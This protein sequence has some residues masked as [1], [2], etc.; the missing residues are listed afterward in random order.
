[1][2]DVERCHTCH[3]PL[4]CDDATIYISQTKPYTFFYVCDACERKDAMGTWVH[5]RV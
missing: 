5:Q 2:N 1:M 3:T 4:L